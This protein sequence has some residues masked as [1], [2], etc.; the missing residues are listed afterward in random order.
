MHYQNINE[1]TD[2]TSGIASAWTTSA[3]KVGNK[4]GPHL[5]LRRLNKVIFGVAFWFWSRG[6]INWWN[7]ITMWFAGPTEAPSDG[8]QVCW[9]VHF[10]PRS[11]AFS[12]INDTKGKNKSDVSFHPQC[13]KCDSAVDGL[14]ACNDEAANP[15]EL[16]TCPPQEAKG[17]YIGEGRWVQHAFSFGL[18]WFLNNLKAAHLKVVKP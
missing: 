13:Y 18:F 10:D 7:T 4:P 14:E 5:L 8:L 15:G 3:T 6:F 17:C 2:R 9:H 11:I 1:N 16:V 12:A